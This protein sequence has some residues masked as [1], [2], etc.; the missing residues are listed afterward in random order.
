MKILWFTDPHIGVRRSSH[1]TS[2]SQDKLRDFLFQEVMT[3]LDTQQE[4]MGPGDLTI[5]LGDL[6]DLYSN[7]EDVIAQG[8]QVAARC[9]YV[10]AGNHDLR[11]N[12]NVVSSL[13]LLQKMEL[14]DDPNLVENGIHKSKFIISP[15]GS[16]PYARRINVADDLDL[17]FVPHCFDQ[18]TFVSSISAAIMLRR[19]KFSILCLHCNVGEGHGHAEAEG[20]ALYLT[21]EL[22]SLVNK[23]FNMILVGHEHEPKKTHHITTLGNFFPITFGEIADR[24]VYMF[25]SET[26]HLEKIPTFKKED[27]YVAIEVMDFL[28]SGGEIDCGIP[29][30][31]VTGTISA[32]EYPDLS[33]ALL[34]FWRQN[35]D[36]LFAVRN[37]VI[38]EKPDNLNRRT[39]APA[40]RM[41]LVDLVRKHSKQQGFD[42]ELAEIT[43]E[44]EEDMEDERE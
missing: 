31:E 37:S 44:I 3:M 38:V 8:A 23:S 43:Q 34:K 33:R 12:E 10:L 16:L 14:E 2:A 35:A 22:M 20:T 25:D 9:D 7:R 39:D 29:L 5:C 4:K 19:D 15:D 36:S 42:A 24:F 40:M 21:N 28:E 26:K 6:F 32:S 1:T 17:I 11:N 13:Q 30:V 27:Q 41:T 18:A